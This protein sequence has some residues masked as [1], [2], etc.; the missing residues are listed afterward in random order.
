MNEAPARCLSI[1]AVYECRRT[2][3]CCR[4]GWDIPFDTTEA[5]AVR[6]LGFGGRVLL[7]PV[8][9]RPA[10]ATRRADGSCAFFNASAHACV[11]HE[12]AGHEAL[13]LTCRMFPRVVLHDARGTFVSL[14]HFCP[15][16]AALLFDSTV[17]VRIVDAPARLTGTTPLDGK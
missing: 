10:F 16:A 11:I 13:P 3:V 5:K 7:E 2:G 12:K 9:D 14:S 17:P 4:T 15:T 1:H 6:A 8:G